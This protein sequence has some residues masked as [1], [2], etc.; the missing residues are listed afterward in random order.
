MSSEKDSVFGD[1]CV[2]QG[3]LTPEQLSEVIASQKAAA[4]LGMELSLADVLVSK[5]V[6]TRE[7]REEVMRVARVQTGE[8]HIVGGYEVIS[9]IG[10]GGMGVVYKARLMATGELVAL[11]VLPP[12]LAR[13]SS[14]LRRF[15]REAELTRNLEHENIVRCVE[16]GLDRERKLHYCALEFIE[17][18]D[19]A[20]ILARQGKFPERRALE[21]AR[22]IARALGHASSRDL[23]HRDVKPQNI[24]IMPDGT[25]KLLDL[26]LARS[27]G[28]QDTRLTQAG[29]FVGSPHYA[30]PEQARGA[31][32]LDV[33]TD[34]YSL[35][36][37][38]YHMVTG[39][40]P[41]PGDTAAAVL[42]KVVSERLAWPA[43]VD[44]ERS[45]G[46]CTII[47]KALASS[48]A[49]RYAT[50]AALI[51][52]IDTHLGGG[53]VAPLAAGRSVVA[54]PGGRGPRARRGSARH[55]PVEG[56]RSGAGAGAGAYVAVVAGLAILAAGG[57]FFLLS[58]PAEEPT[59][60]PRPAAKRERPGPRAREGARGRPRPRV[61]GDV[62]LRGDVREGAPGRLRAR[63]LELREG[64]RQRP[65][66][67]LR[68]RGRPEGPRREEALAP[69]GSRGP[70]GAEGQ[71]RGARPSGRLRRGA[72]GAPGAARRS[73]A[74]D[75]ART[76]RRGRP[77]EG[78][79]R[80]PH[81]R[82]ALGGRDS[83]RRGRRGR[84]AEGPRRPRLGT[85]RRRRGH[86]RRAFRRP[87]RPG[88][89]A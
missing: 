73:R 7:Q 27:A 60:R 32:E 43:E 51:G 77:P 8:A 50:P 70:R 79:G 13:N 58:G 40:T 69:G 48:P 6:I 75:H 83:P 57:A 88:G 22:D 55:A 34:I 21:I 47:E 86:G 19:L 35:G 68:A 25:P 10:E 62:R 52:D 12:A 80:P 46:C 3:Y 54:R 78:G 29:T 2:Q 72:R 63:H 30:S 28:D 5:K 26:G 37:T 31:R 56:R 74:A 49:D 15:Q 61:P 89:R 1:L 64:L 84:G 45:D 67:A 16:F 65:R 66:D 11:K 85:L 53:P 44:P 81:R 18:E 14:L 23:I 4:E 41:F 9:K 24:M 20:K 38:L 76:A 87:P 39:R 42:A 71:G 33:R 17:G 59:P 36:A 82:R